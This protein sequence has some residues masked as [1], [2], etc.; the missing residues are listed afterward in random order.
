[1]NLIFGTTTGTKIGTATT[2]KIGFY[3]AT[4]IV[5]PTVTGAHSGNAALQSLLTALA[6]LGLIVD[7]SS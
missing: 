7:S 1:V 4:P 2:Q 5:K 6:N 3:N